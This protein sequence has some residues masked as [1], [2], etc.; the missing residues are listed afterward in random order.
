MISNAWPD[1]RMEEGATL[2]AIEQVLG[3]H[4][5]FEAF[6]TVDI[7]FSGERREVRKLIHDSGRPHTYTFTRVFAEQGV[8]LSS[9]DAA[10]RDRGA[11][12]LIRLLDEA[13][14]A[15]ASAVCVVSGRGP[16]DPARRAEALRGLEAALSG[17]CAAAESHDGLLV[18]IEPLDYEAHKRGALGSTDEAVSI[19]E[20]LRASGR[21][22]GLCIDT[23]HLLLN[24]EDIPGSVAKAG[25][26]LSE[27]HFCNAVIDRGHALFGDHHLP[28][29]PPGIVGVEQIAAWMRELACAGFLSPDRRPRV[30]CEVWKPGDTASI[31]VVAHCERTMRDAWGLARES[32][33]ASR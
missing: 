22:L 18:E 15:G 7:P 8:N 25:E 17:V 16:E 29:G 1:S 14:E 20:R 28:F 30:F 32:L 5:F 11:G 10:E 3:Q 27:F 26:H 2:R 21:R 31:D 13:L 4:P 24:G 19:C 33:V 9:L 12:L 23:A 6:Q